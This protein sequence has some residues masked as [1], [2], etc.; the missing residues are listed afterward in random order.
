LQN[1]ELK[2]ILKEGA[3]NFSI[4]LS[5]SQVESFI[6]YKDLLK[7][8]NEKINLTAIE[9]D[10]DIIIKHYIDSI[11]I[12]PFILPEIKREKTTI[13]DVG[14][15]GGF[16]GIPIKVSCGKTD[17]TLLDSLE[18]RIKFL[19]EVIKEL[20]LRDIKAIHGRAEDF[21]VKEGFRESY[22]IATAR[23]VANLPVLLE[24]CLPYVKIGGIFIAMKGSKMDEIENSKKALDIL[25]GKLEEVK[26]FTLPY[27][28]MK[29]YIIAVRKLRQTPTKYPRKAG[30]PSKEPL[31]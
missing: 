25:G 17:V 21:G 13:I 23:A 19:N 30:K 28:D 20:N 9:D 5:D 3:G 29:R 12:L 14:T 2:S 6:K 1:N 27:S 16:P 24:Y 8:W 11:S 18:K 15:G 7:E 22:D 26:E 4:E 10:K 31:I